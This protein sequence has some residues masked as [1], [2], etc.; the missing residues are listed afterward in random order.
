MGIPLA[1]VIPYIVCVIDVAGIRS[2]YEALSGH[3]NEQGRRLL[4]AAEA[5]AA[6][7]GGITAVS[8]A[9]GVERATM[10][11]GQLELGG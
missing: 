6:G 2:R 4:A 3:M 10:R 5:R 11:P 9:K 7:G 1:F 8:A